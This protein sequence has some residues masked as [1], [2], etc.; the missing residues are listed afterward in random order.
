[1][2]FFARLFFSNRTA[3][4]SF[5]TLIAGLLIII[6]AA[7][8]VFG[9]FL[10]YAMH[11]VTQSSLMTQTIKTI[12]IARL[13]SEKE[14][15][16]TIPLLDQRG[17]RLM[18]SKNPVVSAQVMYSVDFRMID[19]YMQK[20]PYYFQMSIRLSDARWLTITGKRSRS[21]W[22]IIGA[23]IIS[24]VLLM[25]LL[26]LCY[27]AIKRLSWPW[28]SFAK[29]AERFGVDPNARPLSETGSA[30]IKMVIGA[31]NRMQDRIR[32]L[33]SDR[34]QMLAAISHD[35]RTPITRLKLR[36]E[37]M[38]ASGD[39]YEKMVAD[40]NEMEHMIAAIL[41]FSQDHM[42]RE[43]AEA[44]D[45]VALLE[46][47]VADLQDVGHQVA[48]AHVAVESVTV[49][50]QLLALKRALTNLIENGVKYGDTVT[51][52]V[53][54]LSNT[55]VQVWID[56]EGP[57]IPEDLL[58]TVFMPFYR[59]DQSRS[60]E[61][62]GSGLGLATARDIIQAHGGEV[63]LINRYQRGL[64]V[65]VILPIETVQVVG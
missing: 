49:H 43:S 3:R 37:L 20:N 2:K 4:Q 18:V 10:E 29:A 41:A 17:L 22:L 35:L 34:T 36:A 30:E 64:R 48:L 14:L 38:G 32:R 21:D 24:F 47:V 65:D 42:R 13:L 55:M 1:M 59:V 26:F 39:H 12:E 40:L 58:E 31:F 54:S 56:D 11:P 63:K 28:E 57:G 15:A 61:K 5:V 19:A 52:T 8:T 25:S 23:I 53:K 62:T 7:L 6:A 50:G 51:L 44:I 60:L 27:W 16:K 45:F 46:A 33:I 9:L